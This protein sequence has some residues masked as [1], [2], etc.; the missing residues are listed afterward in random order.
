MTENDKH[1]G[2]IPPSAEQKHLPFVKH[3]MYF[4][5]STGKEEPTAV[6]EHSACVDEEKYKKFLSHK[7]PFNSMIPPESEMVFS[8]HSYCYQQSPLG[9]G[10]MVEC[11]CG[12]KEDITDYSSF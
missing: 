11:R 3:E 4:N 1:T 6:L 2:D 10:V 9:I 8:S 12:V 7:C 5:V